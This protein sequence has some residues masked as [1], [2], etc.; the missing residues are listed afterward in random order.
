MKKDNRK[1]LILTFVHLLQGWG[2]GGGELIDESSQVEFIG[3]KRKP[4]SEPPISSPSSLNSLHPRDIGTEGN[5]GT[6]DRGDQGLG[7]EGTRYRS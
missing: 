4:C 7:I 6:G 5:R 1:P 3:A 2:G